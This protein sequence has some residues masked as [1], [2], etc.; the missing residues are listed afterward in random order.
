MFISVLRRL[1]KSLALKVLKMRVNYLGQHEA[2]ATT[3]GRVDVDLAL[4]PFVF[5]RLASLKM[6]SLALKAEINIPDGAILQTLAPIGSSDYE[7]DFAQV[8]L[9]MLAVIT[10]KKL[11]SPQRQV[12]IAAI[13]D[14]VSWIGSRLRSDQPTSTPPQPCELLS[15]VI[16]WKG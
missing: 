11:M 5:A 16:R 7:A 4:V 10:G 12:Y 15:G 2:F 3:D 8:C 13:V 6:F 14:R 1:I 9:R